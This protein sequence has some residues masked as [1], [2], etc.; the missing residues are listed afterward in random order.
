[1]SSCR[2]PLVCSKTSQTQP[3]EVGCRGRTARGA[4]VQLLLLPSWHG[5]GRDINK[6][7]QPA[8]QLPTQQP[9]IDAHELRGSRAGVARPDALPLSAKREANPD[10][11]GDWRKRAAL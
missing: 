6:I 7:P 9:L 3:K 4:L 8:R 10:V 5:S 1:M 11:V 2:S